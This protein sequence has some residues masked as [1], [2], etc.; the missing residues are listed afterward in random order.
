MTEPE[1][2]REGQRGD[3]ERVVEVERKKKR[4]Y[5]TKLTTQFSFLSSLLSSSLPLSPPPASDPVDRRMPPRGWFLWSKEQQDE[6]DAVDVRGGAAPH[7]V[8]SIAEAAGDFDGG[9]D[10]DS[11]DKK[12]ALSRRQ[13]AAFHAA[14]QARQDELDAKAAAE[15]SRVKTPEELAA[16][17]AEAEA[18]QQRRMDD[19]NYAQQNGLPIPEYGNEEAGDGS[20]IA[21]DSD[22][23]DDDEQNAQA[24]INGEDE[25]EA[26]ERAAPSLEKIRR[27]PRA[28]IDSL[29]RLSNP[30]ILARR[31]PREPAARLSIDSM[32]AY[33]PFQGNP[34][35]WMSEV[36]DDKST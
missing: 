3:V 32:S 10:A 29:Y 19:I 8:A 12:L 20:A 35:M 27:R 21:R 30:A 14:A 17:A 16:E 5:E 23:D 25:E 31:S 1:E 26:R 24:G 18:F 36:Y 4:R 15:A 9:D 34:M 28:N 6:Q 13:V 2:R 7:E 11:Y 22:D 33:A